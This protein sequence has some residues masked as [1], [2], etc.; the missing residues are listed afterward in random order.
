M[1]VS[2]ALSLIGHDYKVMDILK[3][4]ITGTESTESS[5]CVFVASGSIVTLGCCRR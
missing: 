4:A 1:Y 5:C 2:L 3:A